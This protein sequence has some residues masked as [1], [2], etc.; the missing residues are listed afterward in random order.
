MAVAL[1]ATGCAVTSSS[2]PEGRQPTPQR[3]RLDNGLTVVLG[4]HGAAAVAA[5]QLWIRV[6]A[7]NETYGE[8]GLSHFI[9]HLLFKGTPTR[10]PGVIDRTISG[11]GGEM[12]AATSQDF[13]HYH[14]VLPARHVETAL[15]VVGD[16]ALHASFDPDELERERLVVLE[17]IRRAEDNPSASLWRALSHRHFADHPYGRPVLGTP[18]SI[19]GL[20]RASI[21]AYYRRYYVPNNAVLVLVGDVQRE[22]LLGHVQKVFGVW[23]PRPVPDARVGRV[24]ALESV[25]RVEEQRPLRQTYVGMAWRGPVAPELDV[26]AVDLLVAILGRGRSSRL[27]QAL[28]ERL[29]LVSSVSASFYTQ[30]DAGTIM[31]TARTTAAQQRRVEE[32][33]LAETERL[34]A[35]LVTEDELTRALTAVE[36]GHAFTHETAEGG[37]YAYGSAETV[38]T[39]DFELTYLDEV[40][41]VTRDRIREAARRYLVPDR[42]TAAVL[43]P[44]DET[45]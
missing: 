36:A 3:L 21:A 14:V 13:T 41:K 18:A 40:R 17:E 24:A 39:L 25:E 2:R 29:G 5:V 1:L 23:E 16:A 15:D 33:V 11:L 30:H 7:R 45:Q 8:A 6:G 20:A 34:R 22:P 28:R 31:V 42:F 27:L 26:Y 32:A 4:E 35:T 12:N 43:R 37:A 9:E 38:W 19:Q 10:G 44:Q